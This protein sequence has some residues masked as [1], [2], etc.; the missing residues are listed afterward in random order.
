MH[1]ATLLHRAGFHKH[2]AV[3]VYHLVY[4][5][6]LWDWLKT[7][8]IGMFSREA[9]QSFTKAKKSISSTKLYK[10][11]IHKNDDVFFIKVISNKIN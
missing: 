1:I 2:S 11:L 8:S 4:L 6:L 5:L 7:K 9:M 3:D 10:L